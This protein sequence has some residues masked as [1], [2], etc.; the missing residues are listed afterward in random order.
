LFMMS[1]GCF[2]REA[3]QIEGAPRLLAL[4]VLRA[5]V[6]PHDVHR[7]VVRQELVYLGSQVLLVLAVITRPVRVGLPLERV[8]QLRRSRVLVLIVMPVDHRMVEADAQPLGTQGV[9]DLFDEVA[10]Q[11]RACVIVA[12]VRIVQREAVVVFRG[13]DDIPGTGVLRES[14]PV[15]GE[16]GLRCEERDRTPRVRVGVGL[17]VLLNPL[18]PA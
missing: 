13:E 16:A 4:E 10:V 15:A 11:H 2:A 9:H 18:H 14:R 7:T 1:A 6:P 17:H 8:W 12:H 3:H 5:V